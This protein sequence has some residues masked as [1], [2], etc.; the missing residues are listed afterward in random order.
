MASKT[1]T[2]VTP[3]AKV[4]RITEDRIRRAEGA[5][6][7]HS[8]QPYQG[9]TVNDLLDPTY[10][11]LTARRFQPND[12]IRVVPEDGAW[13][14]HLYV[15]FAS[16]TEVFVQVLDHKELTNVDPTKTATDAYVAEWIAPPVRFGVRRKSD[17]EV[18]QSGFPTLEKAVQWMHEHVK[19]RAA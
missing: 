9:T 4:R 8:V 1:E 19:A 11:K 6:T 18:I 16:A 3:I 2:N 13:R 17:K 15:T 14:A 12:E 10:W 7:L 5:F